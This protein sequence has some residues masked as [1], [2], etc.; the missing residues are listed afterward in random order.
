MVRSA[1]QDPLLGR[2]CPPGRRP[3][4]RWRRTAFQRSMRPARRAISVA[5]S[6]P[7]AG[8]GNESASDRERQR[9]QS[10]WPDRDVTVPR[11]ESTRDSLESCVGSSGTEEDDH[12]CIGGV[13]APSVRHAADPPARRAAAAGLW[14][15]LPQHPSLREG[16]AVHFGNAAHGQVVRRHGTD[17]GERAEP[18]DETLQRLRPLAEDLRRAARRTGCSRAARREPDSPPAPPTRA[19]PA[20]GN[21]CVSPPLGWG[22]ARGTLR[23]A[24][25]RNVV[26][27]RTLNLLPQEGRADNAKSRRGPTRRGFR[28]RAGRAAS[29]AGPGRISGARLPRDRSCD[30]AHPGNPASRSNIRRTRPA[31]L[32][33]RGA[34]ARAGTASGSAPSA[35]HVRGALRDLPLLDGPAIS[36]GVPTA[37]NPRMARASR[38]DQRRPIVRGR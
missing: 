13:G 11:G 3:S 1:A 8:E 2:A 15:R 33:H 16:N 23:P 26:A 19:A 32:Q 12:K 5:V 27:A 10:A 28:R 29:T 20:F 30:I 37:S 9:A 25:Q 34:R 14:A 36:A 18:I 31:N 17:T 4:R 6:S 7:A 21:R 35:F 24:A 38:G 22:S